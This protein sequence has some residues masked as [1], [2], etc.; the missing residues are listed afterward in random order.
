MSDGTFPG[1]APGWYPDPQ[2]PG[3]ARHWNGTQ[4]GAETRP[5]G[6]TPPQPGAQGP[7]A[8]PYGSA[9][10]PPPSSP[11]GAGGGAP[12]WKKPWFLIAAFIAYVVA[13][14]KIGCMTH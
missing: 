4:W 8:S 10:T 6:P 12:F 11:T 3:L 7:P 1:Q 14:G 13:F 9:G 5:I 2:T